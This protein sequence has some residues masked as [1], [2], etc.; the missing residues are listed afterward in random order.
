MES[1]Q[2]S[3]ESY[4]NTHRVVYILHFV[5]MDITNR[6]QMFDCKF[7][8]SLLLSP[9]AFHGSHYNS[10]GKKHFS[11]KVTSAKCEHGTLVIVVFTPTFVGS[12]EMPSNY[13]YRAYKRD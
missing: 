10:M 12:F 13:M 1:V 2:F 4:A 3:L 11:I 8:F 9:C 7:Q 5:N 6:K